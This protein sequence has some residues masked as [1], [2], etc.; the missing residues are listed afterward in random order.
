MIAQ[1]V[2]PTTVQMVAQMAAPTTV[3]MIVQMAASAT[4]Q[5]IVQMVAPVIAQMTAPVT[6]E[7]VQMIAQLIQ[8]HPVKI[9]TFLTC[10]ST[11]N[12]IQQ[13]RPPVRR[14]EKNSRYVAVEMLKRKLLCQQD[15][16]RKMLRD[17]NQPVL[18]QGLQ[19]V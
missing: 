9:P 11:G 4:V 19:T 7:T 3:Q 17:M 13:R 2:A 12:G 10:I 8:G 14:T 18:K 1:M 5:M 15:I 6:Q 16:Q